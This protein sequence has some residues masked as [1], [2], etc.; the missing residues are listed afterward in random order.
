VTTTEPIPAP[1]THAT[2]IRVRYA[3][4]DQ[5]GVVYHANYLVWFEIGRTELIR[6]LGVPYRA[7]EEDGYLLP[8]VD[9]R[10]HYRQPARYDDLVRIE[11][12]LRE[13]TRL[14]VRFDYRAIRD[15]DGALLAEG[16]THHVFI[17]IDGQ[18][19][20][21][22]VSSRLWRELAGA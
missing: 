9:V 8:V 11:T 3:D 21:L 2:T 5:M 13:M 1:R 15:D 22:A 7:L 20:R 12:T 19:R 16:E 4:T 14:R 10:C 18:P 6:A 17:G